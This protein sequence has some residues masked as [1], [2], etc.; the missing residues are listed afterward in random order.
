VS[1][2]VI[3][4][5]TP[6]KAKARL[7]LE[8]FAQGAVSTSGLAPAAF[9]GVTEATLAD[10]QRVQAEG[11][12]WYYLDNAY[13]DATR[14]THFRATCNALQASGDEAP[15]WVRFAALELNVK[16]WQRG[17]RHIVVAP[18]S[19]WFLR[20]LC[21]QRDWLG[22]TLRQLKAHTDR[23]IVVRHWTSDKAAAAANLQADLQGAWALVTHM[24]AAANEALV[25][26]I[27]VFTTGRCAATR[28]G[29]SELER[30]EQPRRPDG[31]YV[32][33]A[34]LAGL[35]WTIEELREG[36]AWRRLHA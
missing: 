10:W 7:L 2:S 4:Y 9:Y 21:G 35:Q 24:S 30:I 22:D 14:G 18:Q 1:P 34:A 3:C 28:M 17:G 26:G 16:P 15:D 31:R 33:A 29:L 25:A 19:D 6:G 20:G 27:P 32:W 13:F 5:P 23:P 11:R 8:A 12:D 36:V